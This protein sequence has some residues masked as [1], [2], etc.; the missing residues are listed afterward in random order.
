LVDPRATIAHYPLGLAYRGLGDTA[1]AEAHL[2]Q[3]G[4]LEIGPPDP[5]MAE[6]RGLVHG[7]AAEENRGIRALDSGDYP[8]AVA[9]FRKGVALAPDNPSLRHK[10]GTALSLAG[11]TRGAVEQFQ[12]TVRRAPDFA[13]AH[14]SLGVLLARTPSISSKP[15]FEANRITSRRVCS[16]AKCW[17]ARDSSRAPWCNTAKRS[18]SIRVS[19]RR[20]SGT[21][22]PSS[23]WVGMPTPATR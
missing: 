23:D 6:L 10:L 18:R 21:Q 14:Y 1:R 15:R 7:A 12:E 3:Q 2:R 20:G 9:A 16:S 17:D 8:A 22:V 19:Q 4:G 13:Q 5:L 11:D